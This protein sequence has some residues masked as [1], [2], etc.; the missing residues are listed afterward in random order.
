VSGAW[1]V[2][3]EATCTTEGSKHQVCAICEEDLGSESIAAKGHVNGEWI[4]DVEATCTNAGEKHQ[5][6]S[7]C[8]ATIET[9]SIA[10][11][12]HKN[13][14]WIVDT[15]AICTKDGSKHLSCS[16][17]SETIKTEVIK[18][19]GKHKYTSKVTK[20]ATCTKDGEKTFTCSVCE[21]TYSEKIAAAHSWVKAT[22]S[23]P[24]KCSVCSKTEGK[25]L[26]HSYSGYSC[27]RCNAGFGQVKGQVTWK[28]NKYVG[29][30]GDDG[31]KVMLIPLNA[32][33]KKYDNKSAAMFFSGTYDSGIIVTKC[34]GYG[35]FDFGDRI[36][37]G[38]Y[39]CLIVSKNTTSASRFNNEENWKEQIKATFGKYFSEEDLD[40]LMICIG[41]KS[42]ASGTIRVEK[43]CVN[44]VTKD[45]GYTYI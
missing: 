14:S 11:T 39:I 17:C 6:C 35:N 5:V 40:T 4:T 7:V 45:F 19:V 31:A 13:G 12:G 41:F 32:E 30:R 21:D 42:L 9:Q 25:A 34:D 10:A 22:C 3:T 23:S 24:K 8:D 1:I 27:T 2:D 15:E 26:G 36:P 20:K 16:V 38:E 33:T 37:E 18:S 29:V 43:G 44:T 28:Y